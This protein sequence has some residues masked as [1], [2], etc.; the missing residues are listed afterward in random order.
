MS[1]YSRESVPIARLLICKR[2]AL[3]L[4]MSNFSTWVGKHPRQFTLIL[5][6]SILGTFASL[7]PTTLAAIGFGP[8]GPVAQSRAACIQSS[9]GSMSAGSAFVILQS[10]AMGGQARA[11]SPLIEI[12]GAA[13]TIW[14]VMAAVEQV[15]RGILDR[16]PSFNLEKR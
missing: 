15:I 9:I 13:M 1:L 7:S 8:T 6:G 14:G 10:A 16:F 12:F 5:S 11:I 3:W 4:F 2:S